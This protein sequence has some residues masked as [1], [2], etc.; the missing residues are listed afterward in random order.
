MRRELTRIVNSHNELVVVG[1]AM[2]AEDGLSMISELDPDVVTIDVNLPG[3]DGIA[4][5]Q[6]IMITSPRP[7][8]MISGYTRKDSLEAFEA[9]ELGAVDFIEKPSGEISRN[10]MEAKDT[11]NRTIYRAASANILALSRTT[12]VRATK[13]SPAPVPPSHTSSA[14]A[15]TPERI[16]VIGVSTGGPRTLMAIIP[17]LP[18]DLAAPILVIQHMPA[19]FTG[20]FAKRLNQYS[21]LPVKEARHGDQ[22][23]NGMVYVAPGERNLLLRSHRGGISLEIVLPEKGDLFVPSVEKSLDGAIDIFKDR[24]VGVIL[25][26]MGD[27]GVQAMARLHALGGRTIV[28][29][30]QSAVIYGMPRAIIDR[31]V[32]TTIVPAQEVADVIQGALKHVAKTP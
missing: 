29:S 26:G 15:R 31:G 22:L 23:Q 5:L 21:K 18:P 12:P 2:D 28:E 6:H 1:V 27:D 4:C 11:I 8:V 10:I 17:R 30:E 7:C 16:V 9:L 13:T 14:P 24:T 20:G 19:R 25:T 32:A 3:M